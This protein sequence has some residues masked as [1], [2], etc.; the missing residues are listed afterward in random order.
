M[1]KKVTFKK[2]T[3]PYYYSWSFLKDQLQINMALSDRSSDS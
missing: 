1:I 3:F 2:F